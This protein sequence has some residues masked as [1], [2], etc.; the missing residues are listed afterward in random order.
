M[1]NTKNINC[2]DTA[3]NWEDAIKIAS[4][5]LLDQKSIE[6]KYIDKM[7]ENI[8]TMGFYIVIDDYVAMPHS[9]PEHGVIET[10]ISFLK[11]NNGVMFG[12]EKVYIIFVISAKDSSSH[13]EIIQKI[14]EIIEDENIK[15]NIIKAKTKEELEKILIK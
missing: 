13:I 9:R 2:I 10:A 6:K 4:K 3:S 12:N 1:F 15:S 8:N 7:I 5:P 11:I 14:M